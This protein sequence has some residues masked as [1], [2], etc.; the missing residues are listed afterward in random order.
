MRH[1]K[2]GRK[3]N[4]MSSHRVAL[5]R[6]QAT[7]LLRYEKIQTTLPKAKELRS[8]VEK[9]ITHA[10]E[11][12]REGVKGTARALHKRRLVAQEIHD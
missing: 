11:A 9:L 7:A 2:S 6:A 8:F 1:R 5:A 3:L 4:R 10:V 12:N